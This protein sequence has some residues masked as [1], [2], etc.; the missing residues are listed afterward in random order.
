MESADVASWAAYAGLVASAVVW[1]VGRD[2]DP[3]PLTPRPSAFAIWWVLFAAL[4]VA[5]A[6]RPG[7]W[8]L[9]ASLALAASWP[10]LFAR[11]WR[12]AAAAVLVGS[13]GASVAALVPPSPDLAGALLRDLPLSLYAG[14]VCFAA[15]LGVGLATGSRATWPVVPL[16]LA[17]GAGAVV[18][19][20][21]AVGLW[22]LALSDAYPHRVPSALALAA[23]GAA[24]VAWRVARH[25]ARHAA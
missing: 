25:A 14:W 8:A 4:A 23:G 16:S 3:P 15:L 18:Y 13:A 7:S 10:P 19:P 2:E 22:A 24:G 6:Q 21:L 11:A 20:G 1:R 9:A 12:T 5:L 17:L